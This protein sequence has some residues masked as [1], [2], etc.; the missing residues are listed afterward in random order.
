MENLSNILPHK[1]QSNESNPN[2]N[3]DKGNFFTAIFSQG[4]SKH[5][6]PSELLANS[7]SKLYPKG[8]QS[9]LSSQ[10]PKHN[11]SYIIL[12]FNCPSELY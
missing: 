12:V 4:K 11:D 10:G 1:R 3:R 7:I 8:I 6:A 5:L 2:T 9:L